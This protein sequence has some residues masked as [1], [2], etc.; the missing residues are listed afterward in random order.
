MN[1]KSGGIMLP[2]LIFWAGK[3]V[4]ESEI[5]YNH[6]REAFYG[7]MGVDRVKVWTKQHIKVLEEIEKTGVYRAKRAGISN[8]LEEHAPLVLETYDW[9]V[10]NSPNA[11]DKPDD[12]EYPVW[13]SLSADTAMLADPNTVVMELEIEEKLITYINI[14]KWGAILNYSYI[15]SDAADA[16]RHFE[17][18]EAYGVSDAKAYMT[19]FYPDIKREIVDSWKRLF[20]DSIK[21]GNDSAYGNIWEVRREWICQIIR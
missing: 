9:L 12:A 6:T 13:V 19:Q 20:D 1:T 8:D 17:L 18:L 4:S 16:R 5:G 21:L 10:K 11:A 2:L 14:A 3:I 15:P 7:G